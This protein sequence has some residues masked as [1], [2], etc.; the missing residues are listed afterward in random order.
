MDAVLQILKNDARTSVE[1]IAKMTGLDPVAV[2]EKIERFEKEGVIRGYRTLLNTDRLE[3]EEEG[4]GRVTA[5]IEV[6]VQ[7]EREGGFDRIARRI[8][9]FP[10]V[11]TMH[12]MSGKYDL[13]LFVEGESLRKVATFVS[14]RLSTLDGV[15]STG[16]HFMLKTYKEDGVLMEAEGGDERLQVSP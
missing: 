7:P 3:G 6:R 5:V 10:E 11:T 9:R 8:A 16:T 2:A 1:D 4:E 13:L 12:L 14:R 15:L